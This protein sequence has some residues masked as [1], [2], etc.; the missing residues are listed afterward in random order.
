MLGKRLRRTLVIAVIIGKRH[1]GQRLAATLA[2][3]VGREYA[4]LHGLIVSPVADVHLFKQQQSEPILVVGLNLEQPRKHLDGLLVALEFGEQ[5]AGINQGGGI[6]RIDGQRA[7]KPLQGVTVPQGIAQHHTSIDVRLQIIRLQGDGA[8]I[9]LHHHI[10]I[11]AGGAHCGPRQKVQRCVARSGFKPRLGPIGRG[12]RVAPAQGNDAQRI[13]GGRVSGN[14]LVYLPE[15]GFRARFIARLLGTYRGDQRFLQRFEINLCFS[16]GVPH[17]AT[18][19][20][21]GLQAPV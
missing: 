17:G 14:G 20:A 2:L 11:A 5:D 18:R 8:I 9:E 1:H 19:Y 3:T 21:P 12:V 6:A 13:G 4:R 10:G 7:L 15:Q 16:H